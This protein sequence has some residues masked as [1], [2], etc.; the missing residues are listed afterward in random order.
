[1][2]LYTATSLNELFEIIKEIENIEGA[3]WYRGHTSAMYQLEPTLFRQK[4]VLPKHNIS[5]KIRNFRI[6][7]GKVILP[8]D[9]GVLS[10]F[11]E[12]YSKL[13][14]C[15][16][17][18]EIDYLYLMQHYGIL[19]RLLDF[20]KEPL[21]AAYFA[22]SEKNNGQ[23]SADSVT[24]DIRDFIM[25]GGWSENGAAIYC[26]NPKKIN[27]NIHFINRA[28]I[29]DLNEYNFD[30]LSN[31]DFPFAVKTD[32][33]NVRIHAQK[34]VFVYFGFWVKSLEEYWPI[35]KSLHKIFI[36]NACRKEIFHELREEKGITHY[37]IFPDI[38][39]IAKDINFTIMAEFEANRKKLFDED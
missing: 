1:M 8:N 26:I 11:K 20:S 16:G 19:T 39:G 3:V 22:V 18:N 24:I 12:Q 37:S 21:V 2:T 38:E 13:C 35:D 30:T 23:L 6:T 31:V 10:S 17:F 28:E 14:N 7:E 36:P 5:D 15:A 27:E 32:N 9:I 29:V 33:N 34:G 4:I 25:N